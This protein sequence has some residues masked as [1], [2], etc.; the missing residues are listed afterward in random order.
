MTL[1]LGMA[2]SERPYTVDRVVRLVLSAATIIAV[3]MLL[4]YLSDVLLPFAAAVVLAYLLNPLVTLLERK[5]KRRGLAV[6]MTIAGLGIIGVALVV[7]VVP[8]MIGQ[9]SQFQH[10]IEKL[11]EDLVSSVDVAVKPADVPRGTTGEDEPEVAPPVK[12]TT[13]LRELKEAWTKY[14]GEAGTVPRSERLATL[15]KKVSG[16]YVGDLLDRG[17]VYTESEEFSALLVN[18]AK[19]VAVGGWTLVTFVVNLILGLTGL[20]IVLL[21]LIFLL[22]DYPQ[23]ARTWPT[24]LPPRYR[25]AIVEFLE[26]FNTALRR[27]FRGQSIVALSV[28]ILFAVG[29]SIIGLPMAVPFGLFV[30]LLNMVPYLQTVGLVPGAFLAGIRAIEGDSSFLVSL[31]LVL[32]VF[33]LVQLIQDALI[34]PRVMGQAT[35]LRPVA[36]LLGV[37]VWGKLLGFMGLL[38]A[39]PLTCLGIAYYRRYVLLYAPEATEPTADS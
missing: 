27:Y 14:R 31:V 22:L 5:T 20:I 28:G 2:D 24:F 9:V 16:T 32:L 21:Y 38:L 23:Y 17:I 15:R 25:D 19:R 33:G 18:A 36:I 3:L 37:F 4:R 12:S 11:H 8:L 30:G 26:Q 1:E 34:T 7:L 13:G 35:G 29:F 39:I 10:A 6:A